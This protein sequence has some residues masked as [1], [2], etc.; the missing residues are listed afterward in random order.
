MNV[1]TFSEKQKQVIHWWDRPVSSSCD[2]IIAD[3]SIR[4]GKTISMICGF[5][6][7]SQANYSRKNF[8]LAGVTIG[9]LTRNVLM[10]MKEIL[11][12][13]RWSYSENKSNGYI[14]IGSNYYWAFGGATAGAQDKMQGLTAAGAYADEAALMSERFLNQMIARCSESG[15][16]LW[17]NC[18]PENPNS[19]F[20][21]EFIDK[22]DIKNLLYLH[23]TMDDNPSLP[24][25]TR[26][27]YERMYHGMYYDRYIKGLWTVPEGLVYQFDSPDEYTVTKEKAFGDKHGIYYLS[28]DYGITNPFACLLWRVTADKAY[29]VDEYYF[30]SKEQGRR[31]TDSEHY[32]SVENFAKGYAIDSII[33]DPSATSFKEEI[34]RHGKFDVYDANNSVLEGI[35]ITDQMLHDGT[36]KISESCTNTLKE[37]QLYRWDEE[38]IKDEVIKESDHA[39]DA[40]RYCVNTVLKYELKGYV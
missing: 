5:L 17:F 11:G 1:T 28:I 16:K 3:G 30:A 2:G 33:I 39:M 22:S 10:P 32:Q 31:K 25:S 18:N 35:Q 34:Y 21:T 26:E 24:E 37:I 13:W 14:K 38:S 27:R 29:I 8:I 4:S 9:A 40:M 23:F 19:F 12:D 6:L 36:V 15:A 20:K 7:W